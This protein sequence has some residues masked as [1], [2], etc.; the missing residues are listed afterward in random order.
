MESLLIFLLSWTIGRIG[1]H[2]DIYVTI[3]LIFGVCSKVV[4]GMAWNIIDSFESIKG[5]HWP[6]PITLNLD[7]DVNT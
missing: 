5:G 6:R 7:F 2:P 4:M 1:T 3:W